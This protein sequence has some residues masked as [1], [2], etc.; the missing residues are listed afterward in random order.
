MDAE[1]RK[2]QF[3]DLDRWLDIALRERANAE[4]RGGL[5]QRVLA[6]L[7]SDRP[8]KFARWL[9]WAAA[10]ATLVIT[11]ALAVLHPRRQ[12]P[13]MAS[14]QEPAPVLDETR[15]GR[16]AACCVSARMQARNTPRAIV[17]Q[18][19]VRPKP[20]RLPKLGTF[21]APRP[22]TTQE[23]LLARLAAQPDAVQVASISNDAV[24]LKELSI[25]EL[26]IDPMEGTPPDDAGR[27]EFGRKDASQERK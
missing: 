14:R 4:P 26:K 22:E 7:A 27:D 10:V 21:P 20:E 15:H 17:T 18:P 11:F 23:L 9:V 19:A 5:E 3:E 2:A 25:P 12:E 16:D 8:K 13:T 1:N 6:R 24:P